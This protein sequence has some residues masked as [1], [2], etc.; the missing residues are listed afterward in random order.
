M[1]LTSLLASLI[2]FGTLYLT[3]RNWILAPIA[4][5]LVTSFFTEVRFDGD[6]MVVRGIRYAAFGLLV[7]QAYD[8]ITSP[9]SDSQEMILAYTIG[10]LCAVETVIQAWIRRPASGRRSPATIL[11]SAMVFLAAS[12]TLNQDYIRYCTPLYFLFLSLSWRAFM[13]SL[14]SSRTFWKRG[15]FLA[16]VLGLS[17]LVHGTVWHFRQEISNWGMQFLE[18]RSK[19]SIGLSSD[20][21]LGSFF[22]VR[23]SVNPILRIENLPGDED[24]QYMRA[25]AFADYRNNRWMPFINRTPGLTVQPRTFWVPKAVRTSLREPIRITRLVDDQNFV[26]APLHSAGLSFPIGTILQWTPPLEPLQA[27]TDG[28]HELIYEV[29]TSAQEKYQGPFCQVPDAKWIK[30]YLTVPSDIDPRV[31]QLAQAIG[32]KAK[33]DQERVR[34][35]GTHLMLNHA[36]SLRSYFT[37]GDHTSQFLL[38]KKA[39]HCEYFASGGV[40]LLRCLG[41]PCRYVIGYM[42]HEMDGPNTVVVRGRDAHAWIE[43]WLDNKW[44]TV[45]FTPGGGRPDALA[46]PLPFRVRLSEF[47]QHASAW[48]RGKIEQLRAMPPQ[49]WL[50]VLGGLFLLLLWSARRPRQIKQQQISFE[51]AMRDDALKQLGNRFEKWLRHHNAPCPPGATWFEHLRRVQLDEAL[52]FARCYDAV[53][54]GRADDLTQLQNLLHELEKH[55][56]PR[57]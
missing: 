56:E 45:D 15:A 26:F 29:Q 41:I 19:E 34:A 3:T 37:N 24:F 31:K 8:Y 30:R 54:F 44:Q 25:A 4:L 47:F 32:E 23:G 20:P 50:A 40:I 10:Y 13:P 52:P 48:L 55:N 1:P 18:G 6:G 38:S 42:A 27:T 11:L 21:Y 22:D 5:F 53:R 57:R 35:V 9:T 16:A 7:W 46:E 36:Y 2:A 28:S 14:P 39:A 51:Y 17:A 49:N 12:N 33:N 43:V